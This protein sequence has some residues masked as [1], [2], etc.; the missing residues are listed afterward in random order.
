[1]VVEEVVVDGITRSS[2]SEVEPIKDFP[3]R[4]IQSKSRVPPETAGQVYSFEVEQ[5]LIVGFG[6]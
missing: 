2:C 4:P 1:M 3:L 6:E 5:G